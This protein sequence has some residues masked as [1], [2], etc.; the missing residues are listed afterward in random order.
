MRCDTKRAIWWDLYNKH[1]SIFCIKHRRIIFRTLQ[2]NKWLLKTK[3]F[4]PFASEML[5]NMVAKIKFCTLLYIIIWLL[6]ILWSLLIPV[7]F[8]FILIVSCSWRN[9][10]ILLLM[11]VA[12]KM[13]LLLMISLTDNQGLNSFDSQTCLKSWYIV[14][15]L[16]MMISQGW[17]RRNYCAILYLIISIEDNWRVVTCYTGVFPL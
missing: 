15:K 3:R 10:I 4:S 17:S 6:M 14:W 2:V 8:E 7:W 12:E 11:F 1:I 13:L 9:H 16:S 5:L